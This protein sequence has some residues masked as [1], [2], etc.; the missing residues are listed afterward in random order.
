M[1]RYLLL[2]LCYLFTQQCVASNVAELAIYGGIGPATADYV[3]RGIHQA[4]SA[5]VVLLTIDTPGGLDRSTRKIIRALL[6][7]N[8]PIVAYVAPH[9]ARA[10]SAGTFILYASTIAAMAPG[11]HL[12][13]ASPVTLGNDLL[14]EKE[15]KKTTSTSNKKL[16]NDSVTYIRTLAQMRHRNIE[17]AEKAVLEAKAITAQEALQAKVIDLIAKDKPTLLASLNGKTVMQHGHQVTLD[18]T[19]PTIHKINP[20]WRMRFLLV[21]TEPTVAYLLLLLGLYGIFFELVNPGVIVPGVVGGLAM[22]I[23]LYALHLM[24]ISFVGLG[25]LV[26][27]ITFMIAEAFVPSFGA[28]GIGGSLAFIFGSLLLI[29]SPI[30][31]YQ[32]AWSAILAALVANVLIFT[33]ILHMVLKVRKRKS[34]HG[35]SMLIGA[36]GR[37]L[38]D[39]N[40]DGQAMIRG[41]IWQVRSNKPIA[42]GEEIHVLDASGLILMVEARETC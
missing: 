24:P 42:D 12:G 34:Q 29:D 5:D 8:V 31:S 25:L 15:D 2:I 3:I 23:A 18:T 26:L 21:I 1:K 11:T 39:I 4:Q 35:V 27:G 9:G 17:F 28:L 22:L 20:D 7:S 16:M 40:I 37:A 38:G 10:A 6:S 36:T 13:A 19:N 41:E 14:S 33:C 32:V 30:M